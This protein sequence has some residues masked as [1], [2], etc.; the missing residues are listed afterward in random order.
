[1]P[2]DWMHPKRAPQQADADR[3]QH[4]RAIAE[5]AR[6]FYNLGY[7]EADATRRIEEALRWE[8]DAD[9]P[10]FFG[11]VPN[12]VGAEYRRARGTGKS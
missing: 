2:F 5:R 4:E 8:F 10:A 1:M 9:L 7:A 12:L 11:D 3:R 6:L